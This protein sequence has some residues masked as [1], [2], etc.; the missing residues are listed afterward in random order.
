MLQ[1]LDIVWLSNERNF[2]GNKKIEKQGFP[3]FE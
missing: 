2:S 1:L 3:K